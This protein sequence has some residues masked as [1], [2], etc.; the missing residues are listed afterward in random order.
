MEEVKLSLEDVLGAIVGDH[1]PHGDTTLDHESM[2][3]TAKLKAIA[4]WVAKELTCNGRLSDYL[5]SPYYSMEEVAKAHEAIIN[6]MLTWFEPQVQHYYEENKEW[7]G[8]E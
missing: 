5:R 7:F 1:Y 3:N 6:E 2:D 8:R 4:M